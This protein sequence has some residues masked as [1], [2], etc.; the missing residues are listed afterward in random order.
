MEPLFDSH[1]AQ[2]SQF[3]RLATKEDLIAAKYELIK[4]MTGTAGV[5]IGILFALM[6]FLP[7]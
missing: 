7:K 1:K 3:E 6:R 5:I 2:T 4:W